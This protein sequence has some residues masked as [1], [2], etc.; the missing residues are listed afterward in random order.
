MLSRNEALQAAP[1]AATDDQRKPRRGPVRARTEGEGDATP[2]RRSPAKKPEDAK[3]E[4]AM[5]PK[6][7][8]KRVRKAPA[9][10]DVAGGAAKEVKE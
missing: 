4:G 6:A 1:E 2:A 10:A 9:K 5:A 7:P 8:V 3:P